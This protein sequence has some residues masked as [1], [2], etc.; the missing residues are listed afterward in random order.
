MPVERVAI[1]RDVEG[2][3]I[4]LQDVQIDG[5]ADGCLFEVTVAQRYLNA[6]S[7]AIEAVYTFPLPVRAVLLSFELQIGERLRRG[8]VQPKQDASERY[9]SAVEAGD[10]AALLERGRAGLYTVSVGNLLPGEVALVRFRYAQLVDFDQ[11]R[12]RLSIPTAVAPRYGDAGRALAAHQVPDVQLAA[13]YP[14][15][16]TLRLRG[17]LARA[18]AHCPTHRL[19]V[20]AEEDGLRLESGPGCVLDRDLIVLVEGLAQPSQG[21]VACDGEGYVALASV[22]VPPP[23]HASRAPR[24]LKVLV[25]CSGS[26]A[27]DS[28]AQARVALGT[29]LATLSAPDRVSVT[30]FG[31][32]LQH[33][34][35]GLEVA[36]PAVLARLN[37]EVRAIQADLGGTEMAAAIDATLQIA[38]SGDEAADVLL[39]TDG[40]IWEIDTLIARLA[41]ARHRLFVAAVGTSPVE[42]LAERV[43]TVTAG[44]CEFVTPMEDI[45]AAVARLLAKRAVTPM[46][47]AAVAW[48]AVPLWTV[49]LQAPVFP[50]ATVHLLAGFATLPVGAVEVTVQAGDASRQLQCPLPAVT[51][52]Q[53]SLARLAAERRLAGLGVDAATRLATQYQLVTEHTSCVVVLERAEDERAAG[54]PALRVVPQMLAAGW[55]GTGMNDA[56]SSCYAAPAIAPRGVSEI[57]AAALRPSSPLLDGDEL[58]DRPS[59]MARGSLPRRP[60]PSVAGTSIDVVLLERDLNGERPPTTFAALAVLGVSGEVLERLRVLVGPRWSEQ[61]VVAGW[62]ATFALQCTATLPGSLVRRLVAAAPKDLV[63]QIGI[64]LGGDGSRVPP[65]LSCAPAV[66]LVGRVKGLLGRL[67][68]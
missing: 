15:A 6:E 55:G 48:P 24:A 10:G 11:G 45:G 27:G 16:L 41:R 49:G 58:L 43:A 26:M 47:L 57:C 44:A 20:C 8:I 63:E 67:I 52:V 4:V 37:G 2:G 64:L 23:T 31:S 39:I 33:L 51:A 66:G 38:V 7:L 34:T 61:Q 14:L 12:V 29:V 50:G 40:Q 30:R 60:Q 65:D 9:E 19:A 59:L 68:R 53:D 42:E 46:H 1:L 3:A 32:R 18:R 13:S 21:V 28:I 5:V 56:L 54:M 36:S 25:D 62:L 35:R 22:V 17:A